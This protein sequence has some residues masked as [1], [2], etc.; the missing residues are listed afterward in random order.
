[1]SPCLARKI[2][3]DHGGGKWRAGI[4]KQAV[5]SDGATDIRALLVV[6][7][8]LPAR[9]ALLAAPFLVRVSWHGVRDRWSRDSGD[10]HQE[11]LLPVNSWDTR[12]HVNWL[13]S[14][15]VQ[16]EQSRQ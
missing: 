11:K 10:R 12:A 5:I 15:F 3:T 4:R 1:V 8:T 6:L 16:R 14:L 7:W 9:D 13:V 2:A